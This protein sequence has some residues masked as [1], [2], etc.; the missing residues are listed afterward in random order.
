MIKEAMETTTALSVNSDQVG[1][2]TLLSISSFISL[3]LFKNFRISFF[4]FYALFA[5]VVGIEP[6]AYGFGDR[7]STN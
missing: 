6:T 4:I 5:R 2:L 3:M 7:H 1:Q